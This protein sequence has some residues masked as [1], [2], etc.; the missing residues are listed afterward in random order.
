VDSKG[1][2]VLCNWLEKSWNLFL[3]ELQELFGCRKNKV[4]RIVFMV[5]IRKGLWLH[6]NLLPVVLG[7]KRANLR[8]VCS[9]RRSKLLIIWVCCWCCSV[10]WMTY[11][12]PAKSLH[13]WHILSTLSQTEWVHVSQALYSHISAPAICHP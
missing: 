3:E 10:L 1:H 2:G 4:R 11:R 12:P 13:C 9:Y 5:V 6:E 8:W 7:I